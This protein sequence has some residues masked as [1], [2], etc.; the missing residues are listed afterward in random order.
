MCKNC[1]SIIINI[2]C[3]T[4]YNVQSCA[5]DKPSRMAVQGAPSSCSRRISFSATRLSVSRLRPL[6]TVAYVPWNHE[7]HMSQ[8]TYSAGPLIHGW[9]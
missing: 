7:S 3:S 9:L 5:T 6:N 8:G 4:M 2:V 1:D